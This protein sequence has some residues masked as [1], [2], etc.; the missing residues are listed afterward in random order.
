MIMKNKLRIGR[1]KLLK[2]AAKGSAGLLALGGFSKAA[3]SNMLRSNPGSTANIELLMKPGCQH[4]G[5]SDKNLEF[6][7]PRRF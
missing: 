2:T 7:S 5:T 4:G 6:S 1:R 3:K